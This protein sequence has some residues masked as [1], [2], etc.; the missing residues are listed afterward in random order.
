M[1]N[2]EQIFYHPKLS[3]G[4]NLIF[5]GYEHCSPGHAFGPATRPHYLFHYIHVGQGTLTV[6]E[7]QYHLQQGE[8]F[9]IF[10]G[11]T[12]TYS[13]HFDHPWEYSWIAFDGEDC[14]RILEECQIKRN[15]HKFTAKDPESIAHQFHLIFTSSKE[16]PQQDFL[17]LAQVYA[18]FNMMAPKS[19]KPTL[20][21]NDYINIAIGFIESNYAYDLKISDIAKAIGLERSYLY[22]LFIQNFN[23]SIQEY[24][25]DYR[26]KMARKMMLDK[27]KSITEISYSCGFKS[28]SAFHKHFKKRYEIT[29]KDYMNRLL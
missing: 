14:D 22:R 26:L 24:L 3:L 15:Y 9:M 21:S 23:M 17:H 20:N 8:G 10:P 27:N 29:P 4:L 12:T 1:D 25:I 5:C 7:K 28:S 18:L 6:G 13:A 16:N 19:A 11:E 2:R